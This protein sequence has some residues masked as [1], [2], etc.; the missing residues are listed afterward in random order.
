MTRIRVQTI[1]YLVAALA[2]LLAGGGA[3]GFAE[4]FLQVGDFD[5]QLWPLLAA[6]I[7]LGGGFFLLLA[8]A[9]LYLAR[10]PRGWGKLLC[11]FGFPWIGFSTI[12]GLLS[13]EGG[14]AYSPLLALPAV[15]GSVLVLVGL[16][17][18]VQDRGRL[19]GPSAE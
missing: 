4:P 8:G 9:F 17:L 16:V 18:L 12:I 2:T 15:G 3:L 7:V 5:R 14:F 6:P 10:R 1:A 11:V 19:L 13:G